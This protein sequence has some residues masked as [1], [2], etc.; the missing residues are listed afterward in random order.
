MKKKSAKRKTDPYIPPPVEMMTALAVATM[1][2]IAA[3]LIPGLTLAASGPITVQ[4]AYEEM[5]HRHANLDPAS[6]GFTR[7]EAAYLSRLFELVDLA[8]VEKAQAWTWFQSEGRKGR[9]LPEYRDRVDAL[10]ARLD[11]LPAP[12]NLRQV[13][14]L[15]VEAIRDQRAFFETWTQALE[16]GARGQDNREVYKSRG[17]HLKNSSQKLHQA[18]GQLMDL[19]PNAGQQNFDAFY[20]HLCVLDLL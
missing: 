13:Q 16:V 1:A 2:A 19:F 10:V 8:I 18:Y 4:Q 3:L 6:A 9:S 15:L 12:E 7:D 11:A 17:L 20:D 14:A 5:A